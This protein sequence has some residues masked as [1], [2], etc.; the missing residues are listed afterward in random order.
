MNSKSWST[1]NWSLDPRLGEEEEW[2]ERG[3]DR[4]EEKLGEENP[5]TGGGS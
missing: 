4:M 5:R 2:D 3:M 1:E